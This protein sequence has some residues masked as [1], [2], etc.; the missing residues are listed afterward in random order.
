[1]GGGDE[2]GEGG[3]GGGGGEGV[4]LGGVARAVEGLGVA[5]AV[6]RAVAGWVEAK[7]AQGLAVARAT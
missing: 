5:R 6:A 1:M 7:G 3:G 4:G 2:R